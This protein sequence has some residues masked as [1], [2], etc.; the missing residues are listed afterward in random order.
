ME[1]LENAVRV[2][3]NKPL[4][5]IHIKTNPYPGFPTDMQPQMGVLLALAKGEGTISEGIYDTRFKYCDELRRMGADVTVTGAKAVFHGVDQLHG[6]RV[7]ACDL[8]AGAAV[9]IAGLAADGVTSVEDIHYIERGYEDFVGKLTGLG[10][11]IRRES[12]DCL[13][14]KAW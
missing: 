10:A 4:R 1:E 5:P 13:C 11:K 7:R 14:A 9:V 8:R 12:D 6:E 3:R 2:Y